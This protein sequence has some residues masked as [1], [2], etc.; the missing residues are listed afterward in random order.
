MK[1]IFLLLI[2]FGLILEAQTKKIFTPTKGEVIFREVSKIT[3][4][5]LFD[6]TFISYKKVFVQGNRISDSLKNGKNPDPKLVKQQQDLYKS[7]LSS[8]FIEMTKE[9]S[10]ILIHKYE[11]SIIYGYK[12]SIDGNILLG[13]EIINLNN[14]KYYNFSPNDSTQLLG[15]MVYSF[16]PIK[17]LTVT[18]QKKNKKIIA[19]YDCFKVIYE[20][21]VTEIK[22]YFSEN[23]I[24]RREA[25]V[26]DKIKSIYNPVANEKEIIDKYYPLEVTETINGV[27]GYE[28][29]YTLE[30][31]T[32][33]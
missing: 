6:K 16:A 22:D 28:V 30:K 27:K 3:D 21:I 17:M 23:T 11:D 26:T 32:L 33:K 19:G 5:K 13:K 8:K 14:N 15:E 9:S 20:F 31:I 4:R 18:E 2:F 10:D 12:K 1:N 25:W 7:L 29:K 24:Y